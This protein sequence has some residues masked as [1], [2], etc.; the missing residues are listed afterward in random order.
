MADPRTKAIQLVE[1]ACSKTNGEEARTAAVLACRLIK[2][3]ELLTGGVAP[4]ARAEAVRQNRGYP[5]PARQA[6]PHP[7][8]REQVRRSIQDMLNEMM[9]GEG[10]V[11]RGPRNVPFDATDP[12]SFRRE[13]ERQTAP[14]PNPYDVSEARRR[15]EEE[16]N[17]QVVAAELRYQEEQWRRARQTPE[18]QAQERKRED[19]QRAANAARVE[20]ERQK[21]AAAQ[22]TRET[23]AAAKREA[24]AIA[25]AKRAAAEARAADERRRRAELELFG[26]EIPEKWRE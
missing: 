21:E 2:E 11:A 8:T 25:A 10:F 20:L 7:P 13:S 1:L 23:L 17:A 5:P 16:Q 15:M 14:R 26:F 6:T 3:H 19:E 18:E 22:R 9:N 24:D 12:E 4:S